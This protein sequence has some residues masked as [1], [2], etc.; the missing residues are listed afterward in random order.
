MSASFA[1]ASTAL[2]Q[3]TRCLPHGTLFLQSQ[4]INQATFTRC[5]IAPIIT[6]LVLEKQH[7]DSS[8]E[9]WLQWNDEASFYFHGSRALT[10]IL[11]SSFIEVGRQAIAL[12]MN[13]GAAFLRPAQ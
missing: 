10:Q 13:L 4:I 3:A 11:L 9:Q 2:E 6:A 5:D 8:T 12:L 7:Q 1:E